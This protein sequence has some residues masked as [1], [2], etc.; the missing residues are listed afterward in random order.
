MKAPA[1]APGSVGPAEASS[2]IVP[3]PF[4]AAGSRAAGQALAEGRVMAYPTETSY[5]LGLH[6]ILLNNTAENDARK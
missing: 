1:E 3:F 6:F 4:Q 5:A 2:M